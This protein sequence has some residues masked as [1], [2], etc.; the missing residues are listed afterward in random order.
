[1]NCKTLSYLILGQRWK[2][3]RSQRSASSTGNTLDHICDHHPDVTKKYG[4]SRCT[5]PTI[6]KGQTSLPDF[7]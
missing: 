7:L 6:H 4:F 2:N 5:M 3:S 1:M